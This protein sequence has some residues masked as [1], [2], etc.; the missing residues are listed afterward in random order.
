[1]RV[2]CVL[3]LALSLGSLGHAQ[4]TSGDLVGTVMDSTGATVPGATV[5]AVEESTQVRAV[6]TTQDNGQYRF[7]NLHIGRYDVSVTSQGRQSRPE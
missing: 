2:S 6:Q 5:E 4:L 3:M 1:M 7:T